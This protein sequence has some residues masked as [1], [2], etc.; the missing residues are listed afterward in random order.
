MDKLRAK[1][2]YYIPGS[3]AVDLLQSNKDSEE[4]RAFHAQRIPGPY[5]KFA[6]RAALQRQ[7]SAEER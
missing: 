2:C 6:S 4:E 7:Y 1:H 5:R 3:D